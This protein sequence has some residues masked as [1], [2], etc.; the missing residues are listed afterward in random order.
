[1]VK[2]PI[3]TQNVTKILRHLSLTSMLPWP[4]R[5][6]IWL[7]PFI[8]CH[9]SLLHEHISIAITISTGH[10]SSVWAWDVQHDSSHS[11]MPGY[12]VSWPRAS[13][14]AFNMVIFFGEPAKLTGFSL[15][16]INNHLFVNITH[17]SPIISCGKSTAFVR[18]KPINRLKA[19]IFRPKIENRISDHVLSVTVVLKQCS[20]T[21]AVWQL[22]LKSSFLASFFTFESDNSWWV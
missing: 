22:N 15:P 13:Q 16:F 3:N 19:L 21:P 12:V 2:S 17:S 18:P 20:R 4:E 5:Y 6:Q 8:S 9:V 14:E 1:M 10:P 11:H 7:F